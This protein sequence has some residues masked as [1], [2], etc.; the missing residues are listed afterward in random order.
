[1]KSVYDNI[2]F[3]LSL[4]PQSY[5]GY[6][7]G[8]SV[9]TKGFGSAA[10]AIA[11]GYFSGNYMDYTISIEESADGVSGWTQISGLSTGVETQNSTRL[12]RLEGLN[13]GTRKRY[14]RAMINS[15]GNS[16]YLSA[17]FALGRANHQPVN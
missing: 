4:P 7:Q 17:T 6:N 10:L 1:M 13:T 9:D 8:N 5:N 16:I 15:N 11:V 3:M 2:K 14:L 12:V